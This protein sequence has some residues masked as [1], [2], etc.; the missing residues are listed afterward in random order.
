MFKI[1]V[2]LLF[3][4]LM[5]SCV[6]FGQS[7]DT[8]DKCSK[9]MQSKSAEIRQQAAMILGKYEEPEVTQ[10]LLNHLK[11]ESNLV[12]RAVLVSL[13]D[14]IQKRMVSIKDMTQIIYLLEDTDVE[15]RRLASASAQFIV[16]LVLRDNSFQSS[17]RSP[18]NQLP[19][20]QKKVKLAFLKSIQDSDDIVRLNSLTTILQQRYL[21]NEPEFNAAILTRIDDTNKSA[22][23]LALDL[24]QMMNGVDTSAIA[25]K[26]IDHVESDIQ[27]ALIKFLAQRRFSNTETWKKLTS[28]KNLDVASK[29]IGVAV[30]LGIKDMETE[31]SLFI[32]DATNPTNLRVNLFRQIPLHSKKIELITTL[33]EDKSNLI[34]LETIRLCPQVLSAN[35]LK[36]ILKK[37][38]D[39]PDTS[40]QNEATS[41]LFLYLSNAD[42]EI[43]KKLFKSEKSQTRLA[44]LEKLE[45]LRV[46]DDEI[47][48]EAMLDDAKSVR[49]K[50]FDLCRNFKSSNPQIK[51][52]VTRSIED[53]D[54]EIKNAALK[55]ISVYA[56]NKEMI[57]I[58]T[59]LIQTS[60]AIVKAQIANN[61]KKYSIEEIRPLLTI[62]TADK[63]LTVSTQAHFTLYTNGETRS[64]EILAKNIQSKELPLSDRIIIQ[65]AIMKEKTFVKE[66]LANLLS[67]SS[68]E[69]RLNSI[70]FFNLNRDLYQEEYIKA[71]YTETNQLIIQ[72]T[73]ELYIFKKFQNGETIKKLLSSENQR[74][75]TL[76][77]RLLSEHYKEEFLPILKDLFQLNDAR[78]VYLSLELIKKNNVKEFDLLIIEK[79]KGSTEKMLRPYYLLALLTLNTDK[80]SDYLKTID[81]N[82]ALYADLLIAKQNKAMEES[83]QNKSGVKQK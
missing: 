46:N 53:P 50:S 1:V 23:I 51:L 37:Y 5:I 12:R 16:G 47:I 40:I 45:Q 52:M 60:D 55:A 29:A 42:I 56:N 70:K 63:D 80:S 82:H 28:K 36:N 13:Q 65:Q 72:I 66:S 58:Y 34:R 21:F 17:Q 75:K 67:D 22:V 24:V 61:L 31:F 38:I 19:E 69:I 11:D 6:L 3:Q 43:F 14:R 2:Y 9:D 68:E 7:Q 73:T 26:L 20:D 30:E 74:V 44:V 15:V 76:G 49:L 32:L 64:V 39:D 8:I 71:I 41:L 54:P 77:Y 48:L 78:S 33:L 25:T 18:I 10:L 27:L 62:L 59:K 57:E 4:L 83:R 79:L 35:E 81:G